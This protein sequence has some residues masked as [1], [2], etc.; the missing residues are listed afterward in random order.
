MN[1]LLR[2][3]YF[4]N[5]LPSC[6]SRDIDNVVFIGIFMAKKFFGLVKSSN[7]GVKKNCDFLIAY[8]NNFNPGRNT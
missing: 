5:L 7:I 6:P 2:Q 3:Y 4:F 1:L 8:K